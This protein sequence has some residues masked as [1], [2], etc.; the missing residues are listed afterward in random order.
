MEAYFLTIRRSRPPTAAAEL[1]ALAPLENRLSKAMLIPRAFSISGGLPRGALG[2]G[3]LRLGT[4]REFLVFL[5]SSAFAACASSY[6]FASAA[7]PPWR[8]A[9]AQV[10]PVVKLWRTVVVA[11]SNPAVK[12]TGL[13]PAA[14]FVR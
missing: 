6:G 4:A 5:A 1:R 14:Y 3:W 11:A 13:Q 12:R 2:G 9:F 7:S 10:T 8:R